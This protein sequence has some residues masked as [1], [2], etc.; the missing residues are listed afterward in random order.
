MR[1]ALEPSTISGISALREDVLGKEVRVTLRNGDR[2]ERTVRRIDAGGI[3]LDRSPRTIPLYDLQ[4]IVRRKPVRGGVDG[5][6]MGLIAGAATGFLARYAT[7][8]SSSP[9]ASSAA[10]EGAAVAATFGVLGI[11]IGGLIGWLAT[12]ER[13][14]EIRVDANSGIAVTPSP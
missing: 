14:Y 11:P 5:A 6:A 2:M 10:G 3:R 12:H 4:R 8:D 7:Y 13:T 9:V 1:E